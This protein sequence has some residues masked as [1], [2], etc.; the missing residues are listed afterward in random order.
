MVSPY[1]HREDGSRNRWIRAATVIVVLVV[2]IASFYAAYSIFFAKGPEVPPSSNYVFGDPNNITIVISRDFGEVS[3]KN[4]TIPYVSGMT[5][6]DALRAVADIDED[7]G[8]V[9]AIDGLRS[10]FAIGNPIDWFYYINGIFATVYAIFYELH[11]GDVMRWDYH[12]WSSATRFN[13]GIATD[14]FAGFAYGYRGV[15]NGGVWPTYI[16]D[17]GGFAEEAQ[18]LSTAFADWGIDTNVKLWSDLTD[19]EQKKANLFLVGTF[20]SDAIS[21]INDNTYKMG[22]YFHWDGEKVALLDPLND[23]P[24]INL[25]HCGII[26]SAKNPWN[27]LGNSNAM[28][29]CWMATGNT[30]ADVNA[31]LDVLIEDPQVLSD[32]YGGFAVLDGTIYEVY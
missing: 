12:W 22:I 14:L 27:P 3:L 10:E 17:C 18:R 2:L 30:R 6:L 24:A 28:N 26:H 25:E 13:G 9:N 32:K 29:L 7:G 5:A 4:A 23:A 16:V 20:D 15:E 21:Y 19:V 31:A 1:K 11:P 8:F